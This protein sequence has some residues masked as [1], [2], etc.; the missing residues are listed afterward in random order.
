MWALLIA[1]GAVVCFA[2]TMNGAVLLVAAL[3]QLAAATRAYV[4]AL[5]VGVRWA[6][7]HHWLPHE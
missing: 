1:A 5:D 2:T 6:Y 4:D 7:R 3:V